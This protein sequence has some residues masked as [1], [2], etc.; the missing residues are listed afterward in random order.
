MLHVHRHR[1]VGMRAQVVATCRCDPLGNMLARSCLRPKWQKRMR[2]TCK[3]RSSIASRLGTCLQKYPGGP[4]STIVM[5][6]ARAL[7]IKFWMRW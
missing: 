6:R 1:S 5:R 3:S 2:K 7:D 4:A